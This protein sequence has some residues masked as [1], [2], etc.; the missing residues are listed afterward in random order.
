MKFNFLSAISAICVA[1]FA[2]PAV[3]QDANQGLVRNPPA[4]GGNSGA[5]S[6]PPEQFGDWVYRC[7]D[8]KVSD[9]FTKN[10]EVLQIRQAK[11]GENI[12]N[13]LIM[14]IAQV[15]GEKPGDKPVLM[16]TTVVPLNVFLLE[17]I[18]FTVEKQN[19]MQ[20][21]FRYCNQQGCWAQVLLDEKTLATFKKG[22]EGKARFMVM[23]GQA[24][25]VQFSLK[26]LTKALERLQSGKK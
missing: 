6:S 1:M 20:L 24:A 13:V 18:L 12:A 26:G 3:A 22:N 5:P 11:Q 17:G 14:A 9:Q 15:N 25:D 7:T 19:V 8:V 21:P 16:L 2:V 23:N 10:C 4:A